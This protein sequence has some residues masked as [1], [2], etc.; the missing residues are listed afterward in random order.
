MTSL[1]IAVIGAGI[2]G[3]TAAAALARNGAQCTVF[4]RAGTLPVVGGGIQISPNAARV[5]HALGLAPAL[6][7]A[8]RPDALELR[9]WRDDT[10][11][12][13][14][15]LGAAA[16]A[17]YGV[18]YYAVRR[19]DLCRAL[20]DA[21]I[22]RGGAQAV[23][24]GRRCVG[25]GE[26]SDAVEVR[27]DDGS[28][29]VADLVIGADGLNSYVRSLLAKDN[30]QFSGH[31]V[32]RAV[33]PAERVPWLRAAPKVRVWLGPG[34]HCVSYPIDGGRSVNVVATVPAAEPP[35]PARAEDPAELLAAYRGW[36]PAVVGLLAAAERFD[37]HGLFD[38]PP[39]RRWH[40]DRLAVIG[41][42]AHPMLPFIAQGA[43]QAIEDAAALAGHV[44]DPHGLARWEAAR[45]NRVARVDAVARAGIRD[46]HLPDGVDQRT[47]DRRIASGGLPAQDWLYRHDAWRNS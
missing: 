11:I 8:V 26:R 30:V 24:F 16:E 14:I 23:Q 21:V 15:E 36:H 6:A 38:R 35:E 43:A 13:Q 19:S 33:L 47:R 18:P 12:G 22:R 41:D 28:A 34:R 31:V 45:R 7:G 46:H 42:A 39:L 17:R 25:I 3:L 4:E 20:F 1:R 44:G 9:R 2:G 10:V 37:R 5:L 32:Y 40:R 27:L 29:H